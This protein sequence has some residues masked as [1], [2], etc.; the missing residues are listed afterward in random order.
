[1]GR[2][3]GIGAV[4]GAALGSLHGPRVCG[5]L[6]QHLT[7]GRAALAHVI[8]R[9]PDA[10]A[11]GAAEIAPSPL[12]GDVFTRRRIFGRDLRPVAFELLGDE[13]S[14][15]G[16]R[17]L[18]HFGTGDADDHRVVRANHHPGVDLGRAVLGTNGLRAAERNVEA[19][20]QATAHRG[21]ADDEVAAIDFRYVLHGC[22]LPTRSRHG[23]GWPGAPADKCRSGSCWGWCWRYRHRSVSAS[24]W[25]TPPAP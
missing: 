14:E 20:R 6:N 17:A 18:T 24:A 15:P 12:A 9:F 7:C 5:G 22:L 16:E 13:L 4:L 21:G 1:A 23:R 10:A 2:V 3:V 8:L 25:S 11:A 19:Q